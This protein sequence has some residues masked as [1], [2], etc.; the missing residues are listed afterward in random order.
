M[1]EAGE[2]LL[3]DERRQM[4]ERRTRIAGAAIE[5]IDQHP[6][7]GL[8]PQLPGGALVDDRKVRRHPGFERKAAE[9][10]FAEGVDRADGDPAR[11]LEYVRE[12]A[13]RPLDLLAGDR[14][15]VE[16]AQ[17]SGETLF[18]HHRPSAEAP[19]ET[20]G[21]LRRRRLG[22]REAKDAGGLDTSQQQARDAVDQH[23][24]LAGASVGRDPDG[25]RGIGCEGLRIEAGVD[26]GVKVLCHSPPPSA[27]IHSLTRARW[28]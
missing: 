20:V 21:H 2:T 7:P 8:E 12:Q 5:G 25:R 3:V 24:G 11:G 16:R 6:V 19:V 14:T 15:A 27:A 18:R 28:S 22:E 13:A 4:R 1:H 17:L 26:G 9:Q 23:P 10:G